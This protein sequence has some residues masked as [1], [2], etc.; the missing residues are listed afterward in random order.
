MLTHVRAVAAPRRAL[1]SPPLQPPEPGAALLHSLGAIEDEDHIVVL[2]RDG[3]DLICALLRAGAPQVTH[4]RSHDR[5]VADSASLVI[6]PHVPSVDWLESA[7]SSIRRVLFTN[8]RLVLCVDPLPTIQSRIRSLLSQHGFT[9][10]RTRHVAGR[11]MLNAE[12]PAFDLR[13]HA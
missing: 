9:A 3:P 11:L 7:L 5:L 8:G 2:G 10:I 1:P 13:R 12:V 6:V 4:L